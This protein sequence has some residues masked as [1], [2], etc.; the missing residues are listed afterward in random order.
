MMLAT[1]W[2]VPATP[3]ARKTSDTPA[4]VKEPQESFLRSL[5]RRS[6]R[7]K[8]SKSLVV[9][10][11]RKSDGKVNRSHVLVAYNRYCNHRYALVFRVYTSS[12]SGEL[13]NISSTLRLINHP[14]RAGTP[15]P[16]EA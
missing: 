8:R 9:Q 1:K 13:S 10:E 12:V 3:P 7:V 5:R 16:S 2:L 11:K 14:L 6:L 4:K 15:C